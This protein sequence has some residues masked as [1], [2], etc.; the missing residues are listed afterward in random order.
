[1]YE[2]LLFATTAELRGGEPG[3]SPPSKNEF[4]LLPL[5]I[6]TAHRHPY[7]LVLVYDAWSPGCSDQL[8][9]PE[10]FS[11]LTCDHGRLSVGVGHRRLGTGRCGLP[12]WGD[13]WPAGRWPARGWSTPSSSAQVHPLLPRLWLSSAQQCLGEQ[14]PLPVWLYLSQSLPLEILESWNIVIL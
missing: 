11:P 7:Q 13:R 8:H 6:H 4:F 2:N 3:R 12:A 5:C 1:M 9:T 14:I 10:S